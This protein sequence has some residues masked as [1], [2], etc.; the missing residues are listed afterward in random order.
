MSSDQKH[1]PTAIAIGKEAVKISS[2][3]KTKENFERTTFF[4]HR[5]KRNH[6]PPKSF[7]GNRK[8][9]GTKIDGKYFE[10]KNW[11]IK[12]SQTDPT[13]W[14]SF[15]RC[16][17]EFRRILKSSVIFKDFQTEMTIRNIEFDRLILKSGEFITCQNW[18]D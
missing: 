5:R 12:F 11:Q 13:F 15:E 18:L 10:D 7:Q 8:I 3:L 1:A 2:I 4:Q 6:I 16:L 9:G 14:V 17:Y